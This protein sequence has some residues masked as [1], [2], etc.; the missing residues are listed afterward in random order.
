VP[1]DPPLPAVLELRVHGV[2]GTSPES[3]L[4]RPL[5]D[6]IAGDKIAGFYRPRLVQ[7]RTDDQQNPF[8]PIRPDAAELEGYN[9]GGLTSGS[10]GRAFW[11]ILLP[12]TLIN[13]APRARPPQRD[14]GPLSRRTIWLIWYAS[15]V[16]GLALTGLF[17]LTAAGIG[18]DLFGWQCAGAANRCGK[19]SPGWIFGKLLGSWRD[20][21]R[22]DGLTL[23][24]LMALGA[25][26]PVALLLLLWFTS[27]RTIDRYEVVVP[28]GAAGDQADRLITDDADVNAVE[29]GLSSVRMWNNAAQVRRLR[30]VHLQ[31]GFA[32][33]LWTMLLASVRLPAGYLQPGDIFEAPFR[34]GHN[35]ALLIPIVLTVYSVV[36]LAL[37]SYTGRGD[38]AIWS[39]IS[40]GVWA[41]LAIGF[42]VEFGGLLFAGGWFADRYRTAGEGRPV[43]GLPGY[44][45]TFIWLFL[46][47]V[48]ALA[49]FVGAVA[50]AAGRRLRAAPPAP[51]QP[52]RPGLRGNTATI[53]ATMGVFVA[54]VFAAGGYTFSAAWLHTGSV[55]PGFGEVSYIYRTFTIP[56]I[57]RDATLAYSY[58][59][60]FFVVVV[61]IVLVRT[62]WALA[63]GRAAVTAL[64]PD[65]AMVNDYGQATLNN[66]RAR[67]K[68]IERDIFFGRIVDRVPAVVLPL[69]VAG[70]VITSAFGLLLL[71]EHTTSIHWINSLVARITPDEQ[72]AKPP[73]FFSPVSLEGTGA[74]LAVITMVGLVGLGLA[75]FRVPATRRS[76]GILW[77][78]A[79]FW[80]RSA[81]PLAAPCYA[82]RA[83]P[84][85]ITRISW[86]RTR[87]P[88]LRLVLSA[89]SQGTVISAAVIFQ[90]RTFDRRADGPVLSG[91]GYL[92]FGCVL[93]RLYA[94]YFPVY[95]GPDRLAALQAILTTA[96]EPLPRWRNLWRY[97]DY[98]G[99]QVTAGPAP[100]VPP[101]PAPAPTPATLLA[102]PPVTGPAPWEWH[103]PDPLL[104]DRP[105]GSTTFAP[106]HRHSDFWQDESGIFQ[107]AVA[108]LS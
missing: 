11:L 80:P 6:Q 14:D 20:G 8:A 42:G 29:V 23:Q 25:V 53:L 75:A 46:V 96:D 26:L 58:S 99:G 32:V 55:K 30:A 106:T 73:G 18:E 93:R 16:L 95:F 104:F 36:V 22:V 35:V 9:W 87:D 45:A 63:P 67:A 24:Q 76:V 40:R 33:I 88:E 51:H 70:S 101:A 100:V 69:I 3:L 78:V 48:I 74:Y 31:F 62:I 39:N 92:S 102:A 38:S 5:V 71:L 60:G 79:S 15:R 98:L 28:G 43:G 85:L 56:E 44:A 61:A 84:D 1:P 59:I 77:D 105:A 81:H 12:F 17:V 94:R 21:V 2:S 19:A 7:E 57:A 27:K 64:I 83:V 86:L 47:L 107:L 50:V 49:I 41:L 4:D 54:A 10:P 37:A 91:L 52:L 97:T 13:V 72:A 68:K 108:D 65:G 103:S 82:E 66:D 34:D 90:L 89:H